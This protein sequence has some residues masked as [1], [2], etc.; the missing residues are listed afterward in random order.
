MEVNLKKE[1]IDLIKIW[2]NF[3]PKTNKIQLV[4]LF[5]GVVL[6]RT[7]G[8]SCEIIYDTFDSF[9]GMMRPNG[10]KKWQI[11]INEN[12]SYKPRLNFTLAHEIAHFISHRHKQTEFK[13]TFENISDFHTQTLEGEANEFASSLLMA[14]DVV[15]DYDKSRIFDHD[16]VSELAEEFGVSR[17]AAAYRWIKLSVRNIGFG[18]SRDGYFRQGRASENLFAKG[19]RFWSS[20]ELPT[21]SLSAKPNDKGIVASEVLPKDVW[22]K[23][24]PCRET[25]HAT[26]QHELIYTYLDFDR[27]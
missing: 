6:N 14:A 22:H 3:G 23:Y 13:C 25:T 27:C 2:R 19:V 16:S 20:R 18:I 17:S 15:R 8:D 7:N 24:M 9:E 11:I 21:K 5:H 10:A 26:H 1:A 4:D 12:I